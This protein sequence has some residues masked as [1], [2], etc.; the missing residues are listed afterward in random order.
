MALKSFELVK[1]LSNRVLRIEEE[2]KHNSH[3]ENRFGL[4]DSAPG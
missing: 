1:S 3:L 2:C 4:E